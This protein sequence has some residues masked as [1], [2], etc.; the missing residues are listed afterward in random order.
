MRL[1]SAEGVAERVTGAAG[2]LGDQVAVQVD[3]GRDGLVA[4]PAGNLGDRNAFGKRVL[5][6]VCLRSW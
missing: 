3:G 2:G 5:A 1:R 4:E 6:N